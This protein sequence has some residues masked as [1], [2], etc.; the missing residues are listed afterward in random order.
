MLPNKFRP[1]NCQIT[2]GLVEDY[3][4]LVRL[5]YT[6][7]VHKNGQCKNNTIK[8]I[9]DGIDGIVTEESKCSMCTLIALQNL[10]AK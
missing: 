10:C 3:S 9:S 5:T 8:S 1:V 2:G 7:L 6:S 4:T